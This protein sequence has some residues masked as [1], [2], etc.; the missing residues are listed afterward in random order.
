A[1]AELMLGPVRTDPFTEPTSVNF[2]AI[3]ASRANPVEERIFGEM[4]QPAERADRK[5][6]GN[7]LSNFAAFL[8]ARWRHTDW[9]WGRLDAVPSLVQLMLKDDS[10]LDRYTDDELVDKLRALYLSGPPEQAD[11][12]AAEWTALDV[13]AADVRQRFADIVVDRLQLGVLREELPVLQRLHS[14]GQDADLPP[15]PDD[16]ANL[17]PADLGQATL[18]AEVGE[19]KLPGLLHRFHSRRTA[20]RVGLVGWRAVQPAG[21]GVKAWLARRAFG[22]LKPLVLLPVLASIASPLASIA[23]AFGAWLLVAAVAHTWS[24]PVTQ[25]VLAVG[26]AVT[27]AIAAWRLRRGRGWTIAGWAAGG[28]ILVLLGGAA[29]VTFGGNQLW[30]SAPL[31]YTAMVIGALAALTPFLWLTASRTA[32]IKLL[33]LMLAGNLVVLAGIIA[34][35]VWGLPDVV[36]RMIRVLNPEGWLTGPPLGLLALYAVMTVPTVLLTWLFPD[37]PE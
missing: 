23:A 32:G 3:T 28:A 35:D 1:A 2:H 7:Q 21:T 29:L 14:R 11:A 37:P 31:R 4:L 25:P 16:F 10:R 26:F 36:S 24:S 34:L 6:S 27:G 22:V 8:S 18:I 12:R 33:G 5:L 9:S 30:D 19:E 13:N 15:K 17:P 20:T